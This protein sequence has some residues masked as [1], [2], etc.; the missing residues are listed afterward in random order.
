MALVRAFYESAEPAARA[1]ALR[2]ICPR[3]VVLPPAAAGVPEVFLGAAG[4]YAPLSGPPRT[5][6]LYTR[7]GACPP[8]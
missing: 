8:P 7:E 4:G 5:L 6:P 1:A 3:H 2:R